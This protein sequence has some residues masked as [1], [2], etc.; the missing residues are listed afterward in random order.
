[1]EMKNTMNNVEVIMKKT[2]KNKLV[3]MRKRKG[4]GGNKK[5][6][7]DKEVKEVTS[8]LL[9]GLPTKKTRK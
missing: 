5:L 3:F 4:T 9:R 8:K 1:M 6:V 2:P 7:N